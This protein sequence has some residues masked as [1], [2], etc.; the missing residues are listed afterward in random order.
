MPCLFR[1]LLL[2]AAAISLA[3]LA[4]TAVRSH[5]IES[6]LNYLSGS[7][8]LSSGFSTGEPAQ[9]A[10]VRLL[11]ADGSPGQELGRMDADGKLTLTLP[12]LIDGEV[13][14]QVDGGPGHRDYL[15]LPIRK[16]RV[17]ID[18]VSQ[19][20]ISSRP[21]LALLGGAGAGISLALLGRVRR[22]RQG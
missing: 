7:L 13:D 6:S 17:Q 10:I 19:A 2:A 11:Q 21:W 14:L 8:E 4:P 16:G 20:P 18:A 9:G 5:G 22:L 15:T 1:H 3:G 12:T